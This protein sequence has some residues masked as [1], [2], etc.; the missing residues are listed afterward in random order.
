M[1]AAA[2]EPAEECEEE[3]G[4]DYPFDYYAFLEGLLVPRLLELTSEGQSSDY[5][6]VP[7]TIVV[8]ALPLSIIVVDAVVSL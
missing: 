6:C 7:E 5:L 8:E 3:Q 1:H 2:D 4:E